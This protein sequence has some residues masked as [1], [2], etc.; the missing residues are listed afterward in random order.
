LDAQRISDVTRTGKRYPA[1][2]NYEEDAAQSIHTAI[3]YFQ[4]ITDTRL[5]FQ[6]CKSARACQKPNAVRYFYIT[7]TAKAKGEI[8]ALYCLTKVRR[9][10]STYKVLSFS[11]RSEQGLYRKGKKTCPLFPYPYENGFG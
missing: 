3:S 4:R 7:F 2:E 8:D 9:R 11:R 10:D 5:S 1:A 6:R